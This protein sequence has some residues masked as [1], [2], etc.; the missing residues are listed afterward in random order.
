M[1]PPEITQVPLP[2]DGLL[3]VRISPNSHQFLRRLAKEEDSSTQAILDAAIERY[4]RERR[5]RAPT[6]IFESAL[7][8]ADI[9]CF[10]LALL[11]SHVRL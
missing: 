8:A 3:T 6:P 9:Q 2:Y 5:L 4:R 10:T 11:T 1:L 7:R